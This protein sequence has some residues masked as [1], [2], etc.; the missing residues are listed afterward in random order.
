METEDD[1]EGSSINTPLAI[2]NPLVF[3]VTVKEFNPRYV[4]D[5]LDVVLLGDFSPQDITGDIDV[6]FFKSV[7]NDP[8]S[9]VDVAIDVDTGVCRYLEKAFVR[10]DDRPHALKLMG[11]QW[12]QVGEKGF[13]H[14]S[15]LRLSLGVSSGAVDSNPSFSK[16]LR[17]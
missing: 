12:L 6:L 16:L 14:R 2:T 3:I 10:L 7:S 15:V 11:D 9:Y 5:S 13:A 8:D 4:F 1:E 17:C